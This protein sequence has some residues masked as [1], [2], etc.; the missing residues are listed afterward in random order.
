MRTNQQICLVAALLLYGCSDGS[1]STWRATVTPEEG[2]SLATDD[3]RFSLTVPA[4]AVDS[5]VVIT[6]RQVSDSGSVNGVAYELQP[7]GL[8]FTKPVMLELSYT[9]EEGRSFATAAGISN[10]GTLVGVPLVQSE[11]GSY[12]VLGD[13]LTTVN[14]DSGTI[15]TSGSVTHFSLI[16]NTNIASVEASGNLDKATIGLQKSFQRLSNGFRINSAADDAAG[17]GISEGIETDLRSLN[18]DQPNPLDEINLSDPATLEIEVQCQDF[19]GMVE[20]GLSIHGN[21]EG[22]LGFVLSGFYELQILDLLECTVAASGG[23]EDG[24]L[25][26]CVRDTST[27]VYTKDNVAYTPS[28]SD[29]TFDINQV[30]FTYMP[31]T[32]TVA[33]TL[34]H[35]GTIPT[36][37]PNDLSYYR[38]GVNWKGVDNGSTAEGWLYFAGSGNNNTLTCETGFTSPNPDNPGGQTTCTITLSDNMVTMSTTGPADMTDFQIQAGDSVF[39]IDNTYGFEE[40]AYSPCP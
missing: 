15:T 29:P 7:P 33:V 14:F 38:T 2:G 31:S 27:Y 1:V 24:E 8:T 19:V 9:V 4:E 6:V 11:D 22:E 36:Q 28:L 32:G 37:V 16:I 21:I 5:A 40:L 30:D 20:A 12:E 13:A 26:E 35:D 17:L 39:Q 25:T 3:A 10:G 18:P 23:D 34:T